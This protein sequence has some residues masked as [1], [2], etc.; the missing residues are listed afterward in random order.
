MV[1]FRDRFA[2]GKSYLLLC[3]ENNPPHDYAVTTLMKVWGCDQTTAEKFTEEVESKG[4][5]VVGECSI[6]RG[7]DILMEVNA[8]N[9]ASG[10]HLRFKI[11][12]S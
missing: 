1:K 5:C 10:N 2:K 12:C 6:E 4:D 8:L 9:I 3:N 11:V 7:M